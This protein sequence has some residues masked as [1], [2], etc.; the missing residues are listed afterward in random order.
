MSYITQADLE[1]ELGLDKL[2]EMTDDDGSGEIG[3]GRVQKAISYAVGTFDSFAR[4]RYS[5]PVQLTE[6]VK[7]VCL[8]LAVF[9]LYKARATDASREGRYGVVKDAHDIQLRW[10]EKLS[11]GKVALDVPTIEE[12]AI[13]PSSP[14]EVLRASSLKAAVFDDKNLGSY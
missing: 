8:D 1:N 5:I 13:A 6:Q 4:T 9:H 2:I 14:D 3:V 10:L 7:A 11:M 12:T